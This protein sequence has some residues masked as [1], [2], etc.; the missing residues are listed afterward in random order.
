MIAIL[1]EHSLTALGFGDDETAA[2][3]AAFAFLH[4]GHN[5]YA[6]PYVG[7]RVIEL[8]PEFERLFRAPMDDFTY[9]AAGCITSIAATDAQLAL[10]S[11][12]GRLVIT[13]GKLSFLS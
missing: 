5:P 12:R 3:V 1:S 13:N 10:I 9:D 7:G 8:A 4:H 2:R 6:T 11:A